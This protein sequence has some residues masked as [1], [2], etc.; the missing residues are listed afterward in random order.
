VLRFTIKF[1]RASKLRP[2]LPNQSQHVMLIW[3]KK[4]SPVR[5]RQILNSNLLFFEEAKDSFRGGGQ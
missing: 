5:G 1:T 3:S 4:N 2:I